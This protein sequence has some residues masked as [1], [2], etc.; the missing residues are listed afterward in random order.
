M[1]DGRL[2][3]HQC[4]R[5]PQPSNSVNFRFKSPGARTPGLFWCPAARPVPV[6]GGCN[7][8][9]KAYVRIPAGRVALGKTMEN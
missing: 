6:N 2:G 9:S 3:C 1:L 5:I 4:R 8:A 7:R